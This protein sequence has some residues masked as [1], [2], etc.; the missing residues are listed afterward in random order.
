MFSFCYLPVK[1]RLENTLPVH[2]FSGKTSQF[3]QTPLLTWHDVVGGIEWYFFEFVGGFSHVC[4]PADMQ[5]MQ[6]HSLQTPCCGT[7]L[8]YLVGY[9]MKLQE[10]G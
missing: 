2:K 9:K 8:Y 10:G 4:L 1:T 6:V 5:D 7:N 3:S